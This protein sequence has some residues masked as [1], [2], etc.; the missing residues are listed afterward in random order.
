MNREKT[1]IR[2]SILGIAANLL[3]SAFKAAVG[4]FA[5]SFS[6]VL[7]AVNNL[8]DALSSIV[9][10]VGT[11]LA[12]RSPDR[13]H[14]LGHGR[15]EHLSAM[16]ISVIILYAGVT[17]MVESIKK[18]ISPETPDYSAVSLIVVGA[19]VVVK[20]FLGLYYKKVAKNVNS[21]SLKA[22]GTD[23][24]FDAI[25]SASVLLA[26]VI[27]LVFHVNLEAW[28]GV[29]ISVFILKSGLELLFNAT[30]QMLGKRV[31]AAVT[32]KVREVVSTFPEV[33]GVFDLILHDY[34]PE[35]YLG[36]VHIA[37]AHQMTAEDLDLLERRIA[38]KVYE[39]TNVIMA[40]ISVYAV[41][42]EKDLSKAVETEIRTVLA[43]CPDVL[44]MHGFHLFEEEKMIQFDVVIDFSVKNREKRLAE[45]HDGI[46]KRYPEYSILITL[47]A[48][49]SD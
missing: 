46:Q 5:H 29:I 8:T 6:I 24:L 34:G 3:L 28:L 38:A 44:E 32:K 14:P 23:A 13:K 42:D 35:R 12:G 41:S 7:D 26:A 43:K 20:I 19:A 4:L 30:N 27:F 48:D 49:I 11:K 47:D 31:D 40:G 16:I 33:Q 39:E 9:T 15:I 2:T 37:V 36:S 21:D 25:I 1:I 18:I 45:I 22:S 17:A 10:I